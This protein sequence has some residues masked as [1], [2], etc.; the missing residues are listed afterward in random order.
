MKDGGDGDSRRKAK[1]LR[2]TSWRNL[3]IADAIDQDR[4]KQDRNLVGREGECLQF[5]RVK[6]GV[7][8][9]S[10]WT[11]LGGFWKHQHGW[12]ERKQWMLFWKSSQDFG[13]VCGV[14]RRESPGPF[15]G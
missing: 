12:R 9:V 15:F 2:M 14:G 4:G 8:G 11:S 6:F 7:L 3:V 10:R 5:Q 13:G 1:S